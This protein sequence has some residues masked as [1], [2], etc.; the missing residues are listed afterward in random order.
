M[1]WALASVAN[2]ACRNTFGESVVVAGQSVRAI[3]D[4]AYQEVVLQGGAPIAS[5]QPVLDVVLAD[6][7]GT[8]V[9]GDLVTISETGVVYKV[10]KVQ[11]DGEGTAKLFLHRST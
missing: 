7:T 6:L 1:A 10:A 5:T 4:Q 8:P 2:I 9:Q 11:P 3:F